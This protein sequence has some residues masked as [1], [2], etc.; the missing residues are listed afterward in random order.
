LTY[1]QFVATVG[2]VAVVT[3]L[4][5][6]IKRAAA[7][8][9]EATARWAPLLAVI[10]GAVLGGVLFAVAPATVRIGQDIVVAVLFGLVQGAGAVGLYDVGGKGVIEAVAGSHN[11]SGDGPAT[12]PAP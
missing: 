1:E 3:I 8:T 11:P 12:P 10:L 9:D 4:V 2:I 5:E 7:W 6:V